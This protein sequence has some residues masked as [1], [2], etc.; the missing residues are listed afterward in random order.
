MP[1]YIIEVAFSLLIVGGSL[2]VSKVPKISTALRVIGYLTPMC[3]VALGHLG[4]ISVIDNVSSI[5]VLLASF[6]G[7]FASLYTTGYARI[8]YGLSSLQSYIDSF[9]LA[10]ILLFFS[11]YLA[12]FII[13]W[14]MAEIIGFFVIVFEAIA[15]GYVRAWR[16]GLRFLLV[17]M[18]PADISIMTLLALAGINNAFMIPFNQLYI[19]G[20]S[21][22][23]ITILVTLGF[24]AKAAVAPL[25]FWLPEAHSI[26]PA[27]GSA[28]LS[29]MMVKM[30]IYGI[31]R[32]LSMTDY[33]V[34]LLAW[35][36]LVFGSIT[37]IY[38][39]LQALAQSD[40]KILLAYST[41]VYTSIICIMISL[42]V[43][44]N[45]P[46]FIISA[47]FFVI[48]HSLFKAALF[49]DSGIVEL[50]AH[51]RELERLGYISKVSPILSLFALVSILSLI[52][53]PPMM[54]FLSKLIMFLGIVR[55]I[56]LG[57]LYIIALII[58]AV[59]AA[60]SVGYGAKYLL[61]HWGRPES[62]KEYIE[63]SRATLPH[64]Y[65]RYMLSSEAIMSS[66]NIAFSFIAPL[67]LP[68]PLAT[69]SDWIFQLYLILLMTTLIL[70]IALLGL[71]QTFSKVRYEA[72]WLGGTKP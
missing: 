55:N 15:K 48:A 34:D 4:I 65:F 59:S 14:V 22:P 9:A 61:A 63:T 12:E 42:Y 35:M 38:G 5:F 28:L 44:S 41:T 10:M 36:L 2:L 19:T 45:D 37:T 51:T 72:P 13:F 6:L 24:L 31:L 11:R 17:S 39:G 33:N 54:G 40:I 26:A 7:L 66:A 62:A 47:Y 60:L 43:M 64:T 67:L 20:L 52:G 68:M 58:V 18:I 27:P 30:G 1:R 70:I 23:I 50:V 57:I 32:V 16:A 21:H 25:H 49:L 53:V 29:G 56:R 69:I 71:H 8:K 3:I 46:V